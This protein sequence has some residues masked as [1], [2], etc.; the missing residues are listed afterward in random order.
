MWL[1]V[2]A[3]GFNV[4]SVDLIY[5]ISDSWL[6]PYAI[7]KNRNYY[8]VFFLIELIYHRLVAKGELVRVNNHSTRPKVTKAI[9][10]H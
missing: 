7:C 10:V 3:L 9:M 8:H 4:L 2:L 5:Q 1:I 6:M